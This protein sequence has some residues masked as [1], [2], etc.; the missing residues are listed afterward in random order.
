MFLIPA[1]SQI[2]R[3][4][5]LILTITYTYKI[6]KYILLGLFSVRHTYADH[7]YVSRADQL[8]SGGSCLGKTNSPLHPGIWSGLVLKGL[9]NAITVT[10][11][12]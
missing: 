12:P 4:C 10:M 11:S 6:Y 9:V 3:L 1:P 7:M 8:V 2:H 5:V